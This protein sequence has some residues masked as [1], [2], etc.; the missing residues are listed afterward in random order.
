MPK[1][2]IHEGRFQKFKTQ[3]MNRYK[4]SESLMK[5]SI[6]LLFCVF[7][8]SSVNAQDCDPREIAKL[9]GTWKAG[10]AGSVQNVSSAN[11]AKE[12]EF[13]TRIRNI[14]SSKYS[15][16]G[17]EVNYSKSFGYNEYTGKNWTADPY[18]YS[19]F[20]LK[21]E[22]GKSKR[23]NQNYQP[24]DESATQ[25]YFQVNNIFS[26]H[27][28]PAEL[29][30]DHD[31]GYI[32]I[33]KWPEKK[34][35]YFLWLIFEPHG[36]NDGKQY[37]YLITYDDKLPFRALTQSEYAKI[38]IPLL[39]K[40]LD[41]LEKDS[42]EEGH[43]ASKEFYIRK[44]SELNEALAILGTTLTE[45]SDKPAI[46]DAGESSNEF[47]GFKNESDEN[48]EYLIVPDPGYFNK[49][50]PKWV[51]Q[52]FCIQINYTVTDEVYKSNIEAFDKNLDFAYLK[53]LL[54]KEK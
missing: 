19:M 35:G 9:P 42:R 20:L 10:M 1:R 16:V 45:S 53:S 39:K 24:A 28:Y 15:P 8:I 37:Q 13:L 34:D 5:A 11:L 12:R 46:R 33:V 36:R 48:I 47:L 3:V 27:L 7:A 49:N 26:I 41:Y 2:E 6:L 18:S 31:E 22:C 52:Y 30:D 40:Y 38:K 51:P 50:L 14:I 43:E 25:V 17:L 32:T 54:G 23:N 4:N 29:P 21:Y 44:F